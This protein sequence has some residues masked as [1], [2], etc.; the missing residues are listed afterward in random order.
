MLQ[1]SL[2]AANINLH[3]AVR[4]LLSFGSPRCK[5][6]HEE[7][8]LP[9]W[10]AG[11]GKKKTTKQTTTTKHAH[12][13]CCFQRIVRKEGAQAF[14]FSLRWL[15]LVMTLKQLHKLCLTLQLH[16]YS[17]ASLKLIECIFKVTIRFMFRTPNGSHSLCSAW[18]GNLVN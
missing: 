17:E 15:T 9:L 14:W 16:V 5:F 12:K 13:G 2:K 1:V 8:P 18:E 11:G 6:V 10:L 4:E 7:S 3:S